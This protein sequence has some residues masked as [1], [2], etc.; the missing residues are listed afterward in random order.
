MYLIYLI[1]EA[2]NCKK[3]KH[4]C[5][6][7]GKTPAEGPKKA[8]CP[9]SASKH[10]CCPDNKSPGNFLFLMLLIDIAGIRVLNLKL[11]DYNLYLLKAT[12]PNFEGC[13]MGCNTTTFG[14]CPDLK[15]PS[16]GPLGEGCCLEQAYGC[17]P[18]NIIPARGPKFEGIVFILYNTG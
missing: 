7:D 11:I 12:G 4:G 17:C 14:C 8:G 16:H 13:E 15:T 6:E 10:G 3:T 18:D 2:V 5:C 1:T 9:C